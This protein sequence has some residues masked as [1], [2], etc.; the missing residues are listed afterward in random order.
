[1]ALAAVMIQRTASSATVRLIRSVHLAAVDDSHSR[2]RFS[3]ITR[4]TE[5]LSSSTNATTSPNDLH[6]SFI[7]YNRISFCSPR[8]YSTASLFNPEDYTEMAWEGI[9]GGAQ[10]AQLN[11]QQ[12]VESEH[13]M[14]ALSEQKDGLA[15]RILTKAGLDNTSVLQ[16]TDNFNQSDPS[17]PWLGSNLS[18]LLENARKFKKQMGDDFVSVEHL[19]SFRCKIWKAVVYRFEPK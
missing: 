14:K 17:D 9:V 11:K 13:L 3:T 19:I 2:F 1:M 5:V 7:R 12:I 8:G 18:S 6:G 15:R 16:D 10:A 4:A